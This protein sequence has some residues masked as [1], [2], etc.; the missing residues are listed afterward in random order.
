MRS[1][2]NSQADQHTIDAL[3]FFLDVLAADEQACRELVARPHAAQLLEDLKGE[4]S[5]WGDDEGAQAIKLVPALP[6]Q[7]F[8]QL[9]ATV[10]LVKQSCTM[11]H[12]QG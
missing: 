5:G 3:H 2:R 7:L 10:V 12:V 4:L 8:E 6:E 9:R 11:L 1:G